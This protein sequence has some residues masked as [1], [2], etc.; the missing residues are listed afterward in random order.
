MSGLKN[1]SN[2]INSDHIFSAP[3]TYTIT[4]TTTSASGRNVLTEEVTILDKPEITV[5]TEGII[6]MNNNPQL[7]IS[8]E[9]P[10]SNY[11][12]IWRDED[13]IIVGNSAQTTVYKGGKYRVIATS[14][15][16]CESDELTINIM[17]SSKT[18]ISI[19]DVSSKDN[20]DNNYIRI[21]I[22]N[23]GAGDYE[24]RL[25]DGNSNIIYDYQEN[26]IFENLNGGVYRLEVVDKNG[27]GAVFFEIFLIN[28]PKFFSPNGDNQ[29]EYWQINRIDKSYYKSGIISIF[30]R[31]G[32]QIAKFTT[33]DL[34]WD[35][36]FNGKVLSSNNYWYKVVLVDQN[37]N[38][39]IRTGNFSLIRN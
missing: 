37:D 11:S 23:L 39:K 16:G 9:K 5:I 28:F 7:Q 36:T 29:N 6:C 38:V 4:C 17:E 15:N 35:G 3:G 21:D 30:N 14:N 33:D 31:Y 24:F 13:D 12:Y 19:D 26:P 8:V 27:C 25:L 32:S 34:G 1:T 10:N 18:T 20:S 2:E 22:A